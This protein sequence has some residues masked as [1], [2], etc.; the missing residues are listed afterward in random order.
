[1]F[2]K[3]IKW[4]WERCLWES[5]FRR[6]PGEPTSCTDGSW[7]IMPLVW[8]CMRY[9]V[10][11]TF[12]LATR[13][14][15]GFIVQVPKHGCKQHPLIYNAL[16]KVAFT[17]LYKWC[18]IFYIY[19]ASKDPTIFFPTKYSHFLLKLITNPTIVQYLSDGCIVVTTKVLNLPQ[20]EKKIWF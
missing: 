20:I 9:N 16:L 4:P 13:Y 17:A 15:W 2:W 5:L 1:M 10:K 3:C 7:Q 11:V 14:F 12:L 18:N 6:A 8:S 19:I